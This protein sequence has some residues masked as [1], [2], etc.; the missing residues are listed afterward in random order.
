MAD[1]SIRYCPNCQGSAI[2]FSLLAGGAAEC[3]SCKWAGKTDDLIDVK[4][5]HMFGGDEDLFLNFSKD[6]REVIKKSMASPAFLDTLLR[7]GLIPGGG[8]SNDEKIKKQQIAIFGRYIKAAA[9]GV[10]RSVVE[11]RFLLEVGTPKDDLSI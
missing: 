7:W 2:N 6:M 3:S 5:G 10:L 4:F 8:I 1:P 9:M 11:E